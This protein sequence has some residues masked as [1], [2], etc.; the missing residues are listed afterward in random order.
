MNVHS[1]IL[2]YPAFDA[3]YGVEFNLFCFTFSPVFFISFST[4]DQID[5]LLLPFFAIKK[6]KY[7]TSHHIPPN[8]KPIRNNSL[9]FFPIDLMLHSILLP[10]LNEVIITYKVSVAL[11]VAFAFAIESF[12]CTIAISEFL[13]RTKKERLQRTLQKLQ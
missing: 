3:V 11:A 4:V 12:L 13:K 8:I 7:H 10:K 1:F 5:S 9:P 2:Y 6:T